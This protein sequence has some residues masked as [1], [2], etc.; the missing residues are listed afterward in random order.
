MA[1]AED[2]L[3]VLHALHEGAEAFMTDG[4]Q[5]HFMGRLNVLAIVEFVMAIWQMF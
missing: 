1:G 3:E 2:V 4:V 5:F